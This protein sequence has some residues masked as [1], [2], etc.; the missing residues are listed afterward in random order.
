MQHT[1]HMS[2]HVAATWTRTWAISRQPIWIDTISESISFIHWVVPDPFLAGA[3]LLTV[4]SIYI[5]SESGCLLTGGISVPWFRGWHLYRGSWHS[6]ISRTWLLL[7]L[8]VIFAAQLQ[9]EE[10]T[11]S[12]KMPT[13]RGKKPVWPFCSTR[14]L[15][16]CCMRRGWYRY[17]RSASCFSHSG[18][19]RDFSSVLTKSFA[20]DLKH[21]FLWAS[22]KTPR[23]QR[24]LLT[25]FKHK[26]QGAF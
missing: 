18:K 26:S 14:L 10:M 4:S 1:A 11:Y 2:H 13:L 9:N 8:H 22:L 17:L 21:F 24:Y 15:P 7:H 5:T 19:E 3:L 25:I 20:S 23:Q 16:L 6:D 12:P